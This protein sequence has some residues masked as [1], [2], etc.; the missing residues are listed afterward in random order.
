MM[1]RSHWDAFCIVPPFSVSFLI[2]RKSTERW[3]SQQV[4]GPKGL[5]SAG[6]RSF[7]EVFRAF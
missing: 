7:C 4:P 5:A 1:L 2:D 3:G 6:V